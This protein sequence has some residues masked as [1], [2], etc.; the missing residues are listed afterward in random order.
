MLYYEIS[1]NRMLID[2]SF[3]FNIAVM[4]TNDKQETA[5][6]HFTG[7]MNCAQSV[8]LAYADN[9][10]VD[11]ES[12]IKIG[13]AFGAGM[14]EGETCGAISGALMVI[15]L[16]YGR[17]H[18]S[19]EIREKVKEVSQIFKDEFAAHMGSL[20]CKDL[21]GMNLKHDPDYEKARE[22]GLFESRCPLFIRYAITLIDKLEQDKV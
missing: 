18:S 21:L 15:G 12:L 8:M 7:E 1:G 20:K 14:G 13:A 4:T 5:L 2:R 17:S 19:E 22:L 6:D 10:E 9:L 3:Y 16:R 11:R